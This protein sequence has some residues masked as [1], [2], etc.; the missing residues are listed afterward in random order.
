MMAFVY[1]CILQTSA[2]PSVEIILHSCVICETFVSRWSQF[3]ND[4]VLMNV[5]AKNDCH[6][7]STVVTQLKNDNK[8]KVK[9]KT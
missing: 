2:D 6:I 7:N 4:R 3:R 5:A 1:E 8:L 9:H